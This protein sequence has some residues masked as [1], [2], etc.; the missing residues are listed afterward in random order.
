MASKKSD[1]KVLKGQEAEDRVKQYIKRMNRPFGAVDV[2]A[3]LKGSV[4]K[5]AT[6]KILLA[7]ADK[8]DVTQKVYGKTTFFVA[9]QSTIPSIPVET[10]ATLEEECKALD[11]SNKVLSVEVKGLSNELAKLKSTPTDEELGK[12]LQAAEESAAKLQSHLLPLRSGTPLVSAAELKEIDQEWTKW[13]AEWVRR[14]KVWK[15]LWALISD[16]LDTSS[17]SELLEDL[18]VEQD[19]AEHVAVERGSLCAVGAAIGRR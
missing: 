5:T 18:G 11:E 2:S 3:N 4:P 8:G 19:T 14:R 6:Q 12:E 1:V 17:A 7:L 15:T 9:N 10:L 13:R 16:S